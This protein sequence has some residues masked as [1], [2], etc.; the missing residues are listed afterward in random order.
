MPGWNEVLREIAGQ[1]T[2]SPLDIVRRKYLEETTRHTKRNAI[3]YYSGWLTKGSEIRG[4][5]ISDQDM[6]AFMTT[7]HKLDRSQGLDLILHTPGG[8][9]AATEA[10][11]GYLRNMF[12]GDL[13]AIVP[14][15]AMSA[16]TMIACACQEILMGKQSNLGPIDPQMGG[17]SAHG[18]LEEFQRA[19]DEVKRDPQRIPIWQTIIGKYHPTFLGDCQ[20]AITWSK[21]MVKNWLITGMFAG[22]GTDATDTVE[23]IVDSL[24]DH[25]TTATHSRHIPME[26]LQELG[27]KVFPIENDPKLQDLVLTTHHA[28][29]HTFANSQV[30]KIVE[31]QLGACVALH[32]R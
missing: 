31:N 18:V 16:G 7:V 25:N 1:D 24:S 23:M 12:R 27:L 10:I 22:E 17:V 11:V 6:N 19:I 30:I 9:I 3:A 20:Q 5:E 2:T 28:F 13:R 4:I 8:D 21:A 32:V 26:Q 29:M 14:Q 15:L